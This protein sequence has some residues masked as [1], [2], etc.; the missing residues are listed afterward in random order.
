VEDKEKLPQE[1]QPITR[2]SLG[3]II[4]KNQLL[5]T[6]DRYFPSSE[7][8]KKIIKLR[9]YSSANKETNEAKRYSTAK[10]PMGKEWQDV[11]QPGLSH[12]EINNWTNQGGWIGMVIPD[13]YDL[14]DIDDPQEG[15]LIYQAL[16]GEGFQFHAIRTPNGYQ[17]F[18]RSTGKLKRQNAKVLMAGGF[19]GDYRLAGKGQIVFPTE[20]TPGRYWIHT[21]KKELSKTP[22]MFEFLKN[23]GKKDRPFPIPV[24][25]GSR[26]NTLYSHACRLVEFGYKEKDIKSVC[27][28]LN[29]Y[30]FEPSL[31]DLE[32]QKT[33]KSAFQQK[34]SGRDYS[35]STLKED[36]GSVSWG[37]FFF[38]DQFI[39]MLL[40]EWFL[41]EYHFF[42]MAGRL[43]VYQDGVYKPIGEEF[44]KKKAIEVL[45]IKAKKS[46]VEETVYLIKSQT[47]VQPSQVNPNPRLINLLNGFFDM[48]ELELK[49]HDPSI[50]STIQ[51]PVKYDRYAKCPTIQRFI[52][53]IMP[54]DC[55]NL[56]YE[57]AGYSLVPQVGYDKAFMLY[58]SGGNGKGTLINLLS[59]F[60]G[61][62]NASSISLQDMTD[63]RFRKAEI[64]GRLINV[65]A[66]LPARAVLDGAD[67]KMMV[68]G[69]KMTAERKNCDPFEFRPFAKHIFSANQLPKGENTEAFFDRWIV[70]PFPHKFRGSGKGDKNLIDK[71]TTPEELSG[72]FNLAI[73][74]L[75]RLEMQNGFSESETVNRM[76][77]E[78]RKESDSVAGFIDECCTI[79]P[80]VWEY[81]Q[82][83]YREYD[84][85]CQEMGFRP[86]SSIKFNQRL[87]EIVPTVLEEKE[88]GGKRRWKGICVPSEFL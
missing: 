34:P 13:G 75:W 53:E 26:D 1:E 28:F 18:F 49:P 63:N 45:G 20:G 67:F 5:K 73:D 56:I 31:T 17:F 7:K 16:K 68:S 4:P 48:D 69:D 62:E 52:S 6:L 46:R 24:N 47:V 65:Y 37:H 88:K 82:G 39:P 76:V 41:K 77:G 30:F 74:G 84:K 60:I 87:K 70:I 57:F 23:I 51:I 10:Q 3:F 8:Q 36:F 78:Y 86:V 35:V 85:W 21:A 55:V 9:G 14:I 44:V 29:Q 80:E 25:E 11:D 15:E 19:V 42:T 50:L 54:G 81:K 61:E 72:F 2:D 59:R 22:I 83:L 66:D 43:Y 79:K 38:D 27:Q 71:M 64:F 40:V 32:F 12:E 33:V 58:G